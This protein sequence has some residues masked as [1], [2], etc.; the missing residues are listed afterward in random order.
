MVQFQ[1]LYG[2]GDVVWFEYVQCIGFV[3]GDIVEGVVVGVDFVYDYYGGV[4]L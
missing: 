4:V 2:M 3:G 1:F